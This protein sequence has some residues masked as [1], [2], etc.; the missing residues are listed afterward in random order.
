M[1]QKN[2]GRMLAA[3]CC[4]ILI[5]G[6]QTDGGGKKF[7][8]SLITAEISYKK[9][10]GELSG[11]WSFFQRNQSDSLVPDAQHHDFVINGQ[12]VKSEKS[13]HNYHMYMVTDTLISKMLNVQIGPE[14]QVVSLPIPQ[15][16]AVE[17]DT[18]DMSADWTVRWK[19]GDYSAEDSLTI[20]FSDENSHTLMQKVPTSEGELTVPVTGLLNMRAGSGYYY[21]ISSTLQKKDLGGTDLVCRLEVYSDNFPLEII[22]PVAD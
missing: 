14:N 7:G 15:I 22:S 19:A 21:V 9:Y 5:W 10:S 20:V 12:R 18:L 2:H 13:K 4:G 11:N 8:N 1:I 3:L 6:C 17:A 16:P